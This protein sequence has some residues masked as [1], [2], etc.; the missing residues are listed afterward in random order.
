MSKNPKTSARKFT[1][2]SGSSV[3]TDPSGF[4]YNAVGPTQL[5]LFSSKSLLKHMVTPTSQLDPCLAL[6]VLLDSPLHLGLDRMKHSYAS[7]DQ[8]V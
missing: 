3:V 5:Q 6:Q 8:S 4:S 7:Q 1:L 2:L